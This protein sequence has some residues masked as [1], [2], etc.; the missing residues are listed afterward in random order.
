M[1]KRGDR[2]ARGGV[3]MAL[4]RGR[5][6]PSS[7]SFLLAALSHEGVL[8]LTPWLLAAQARTEPPR[9]GTRAALGLAVTPIVFFGVRWALERAH[10][11]V[12]YTFKYYLNAPLQ[13]PLHF[14]P[15][16]HVAMGVVDALGPK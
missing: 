7:A 12:A 3:L 6:V 16:V 1:G 2:D 11:G 9:G 4:A 14:I 13:D 15:R 10:P 8:F 5:I